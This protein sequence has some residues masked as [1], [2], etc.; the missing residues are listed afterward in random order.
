MAAYDVSGLV[1]VE[2]AKH[3]TTLGLFGAEVE[4]MHTRMQLDESDVKVVNDS[5]EKIVGELQASPAGEHIGFIKELKVMKEHNIPIN[6][7]HSVVTRWDGYAE[8]KKGDDVHFPGAV[9]SKLAGK[10][11]AKIAD[12]LGI[13]ESAAE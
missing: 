3:H 4:R 10:V 6:D 1:A 13:A 9:Y 2:V 7:L 8:W 11:A 5:V 12:E